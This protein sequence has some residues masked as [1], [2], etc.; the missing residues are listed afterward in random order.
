MPWKDEDVEHKCK[1]H[2]RNRDVSFSP[3]ILYSWL[4]CLSLVSQSR[5]ASSSARL[6]KEENT[7]APASM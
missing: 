4:K 6:S 2:W 5:W 1:E 3:L 7:A